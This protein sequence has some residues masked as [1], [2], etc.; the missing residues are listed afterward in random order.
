MSASNH[1]DQLVDAGVKRR[2][3][4][5]VQRIEKTTPSTEARMRNL[6]RSGAVASAVNK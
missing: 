1:W 4:L 5:G 2:L 6:F 3:T